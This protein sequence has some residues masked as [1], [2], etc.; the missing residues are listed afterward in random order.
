MHSILFLKLG[1][2]DFPDC[3]SILRTG[4][5]P[6][7][8]KTLKASFALLQILTT[9]MA[10][11]NILERGKIPQLKKKNQCFSLIVIPLSL[12]H[13]V[14]LLRNSKIIKLLGLPSSLS[15]GV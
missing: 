13:L 11:Q 6:K 4:V 12:H 10:I 3:I 8:W 15:T 7:Q 5:W 2:T 14:L 1:I 9:N